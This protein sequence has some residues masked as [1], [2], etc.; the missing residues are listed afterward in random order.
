[1]DKLPFI[2]AETGLLCDSEVTKKQCGGTVIGLGHIKTRRLTEKTLRN[3]PDLH[4]GDC[5]PFYF[6]PRSVMLFYIHKNNFGLDYKGGQEPIIHLVADLQETVD[7]ANENKQRWAFTTSNA[8][9]KYFED[10]ADLKQLN[11]IN[12]ESVNAEFWKDCKEAK[13][14]EFLLERYFPWYLVKKIGVHSDGIKQ[15]VIS[16]LNSNEHRPN[17]EIKR[18]W[19][20]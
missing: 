6:S 12:W 5:V 20:Y 10:Y 17:V 2:L 7:W 16:I 15:R 3:Y 13:Q 19:Y 11:K 4:V 1:V 8:G 9:S 14:A 18:E